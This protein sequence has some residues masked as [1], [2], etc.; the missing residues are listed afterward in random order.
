VSA[1]ISPV[2]VLTR[3]ILLEARRG[4]LPWLALATLAVSLAL[5][6]FVS[7][8]ALSES[9]ALQA[10][11]LGALL[12]ASAVFLVAAQVIAS[13]LR[14]MNDR[15][16]ELMLSLAHSRTTH[17]VG[18]LAGFVACAALLAAFFAAPLLIWA[19]PGAVALWALSL[20]CEA[21]L[22]AAAALF[23]AMSLGQFASAMAATVGLYLLAR[24]I[25]AIQAIAS[26]PLA[27]ASL[28]AQIAHHSV[29]ALGLLLPPLDALTRTAWL[30]YEAPA[31]TA[32]AAALG[33]A[34]LYTVL[35]AAAGLF[36]F[37]RRS[38]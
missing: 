19:A 26:G 1:A 34:L 11:L 13:T 18:R 30:L 8:V 15:G 22:V 14:E 20:A 2:L 27:E 16:L 23:F 35:L 25:G 33:S 6:A 17:Y 9:A 7:H 32:Y 24:S 38:L 37:H 10:A 3:A 28:A 12:R 29:D 31:P 36:D 4:G 21:A 5:A